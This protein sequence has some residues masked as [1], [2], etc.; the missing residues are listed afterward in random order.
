[1]KKLSKILLLLAT[2]AI[3]LGFTGCQNFNLTDVLNGEEILVPNFSLESLLESNQ[4]LMVSRA[5][6]DET[7]DTY[8]Y[9]LTDFNDYMGGET[10]EFYFNLYMY[11]GA[12]TV[13]SFEKQVVSQYDT[14]VPIKNNNGKHYA[15]GIEKNI[16]NGQG[17]KY[18]FGW[19]YKDSR[20]NYIEVTI[21]NIGN[22]NIIIEKTRFDILD[23]D[24]D[25]TKTEY[26]T[27]K[28]IM[29]TISGDMNSG[30]YTINFEGGIYFYSKGN[31][32]IGEVYAIGTISISPEEYSFEI[33]EWWEGDIIPINTIEEFYSSDY[34]PSNITKNDLTK[35]DPIF[36]KITWDL[37]TTYT[38]N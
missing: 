34:D 17:R 20:N 33:T 26:A 32:G 27:S 24:E 8:L 6:G 18:H 22:P 35:V 36:N 16:N 11:L 19:E 1:M 3:L 25:F 2:M 37:G 29:Y 14:T 12:P 23:I 7:E 31:G 13:R 38:V 9:D 5:S 30:S 21:D 10:N 15:Y 28:N 4:A